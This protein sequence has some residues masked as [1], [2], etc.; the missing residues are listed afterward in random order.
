MSAW[1]DLGS[2]TGRARSE[3]FGLEKKE[4]NPKNGRAKR[5]FNEF[6]QYVGVTDAGSTGN[7]FTWSNNKE[8]EARIWERLD[9]CL[10]NGMGL[11]A[12]P[13]LE[14]QHLARLCLDHCPLLLQ[15]KGE[16]RCR[17]GVFK[18]LGAWLDREGCMD[19]VKSSWLRKPIRIPF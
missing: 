3:K 16:S 19:V 12:F 14:I 9:R 11:A 10:V 2:G 15:F 13:N 6:I 8:G 7:E 1:C 17:K 5:E 18:F 4:G